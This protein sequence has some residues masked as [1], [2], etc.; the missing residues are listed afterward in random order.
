[1]RFTILLL[2][3]ASTITARA[4][5]ELQAEEPEEDIQIF[6]IPEIGLQAKIPDEMME[7]EDVA[8]I[9]EETSKVPPH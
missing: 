3:F 6:S 7:P 1:M 2:A 4:T 9:T 5:R 8:V